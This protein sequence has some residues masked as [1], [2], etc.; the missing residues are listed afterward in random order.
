MMTWDIPLHCIEN[1]PGV[2]HD[3]YVS[4]IMTSC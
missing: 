2:C 3:E 4:I 1:N